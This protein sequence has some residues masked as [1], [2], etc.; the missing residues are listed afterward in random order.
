MPKLVKRYARSRLYDT[1]AARDVTVADLREC[2]RSASHS[3][4][5]TLKPDKMRPGFY[6]PRLAA[7]RSVASRSGPSE[8]AL[9]GAE[10]HL[11]V[12]ML[13]GRNSTRTSDNPKRAALVPIPTCLVPSALGRR[14]Q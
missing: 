9:T 8:W 1:E 3:W 6:W 12:P 4:S 5:S 11:V 2:Q 13:P 14:S 7:S 10:L